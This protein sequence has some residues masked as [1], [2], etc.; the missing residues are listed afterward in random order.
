MKK[1]KYEQNG[2]MVEIEVT[3]NDPATL[4]LGN[5]STVH[6]GQSYIVSLEFSEINTGNKWIQFEHNA[7]GV[8]TYQIPSNLHAGAE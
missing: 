4:Y 1:I 5:G 2:K 6:I 7:N 3:D 8:L